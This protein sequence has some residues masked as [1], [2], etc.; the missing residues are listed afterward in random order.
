MALIIVV[1]AY[2]ALEFISSYKKSG[3][4]IIDII[5][6]DN[7]IDKEDESIVNKE[8]TAENNTDNNKEEIH[9]EQIER[10]KGVTEETKEIEKKEEKIY[11]YVTGEINTPG[12]VILNKG[13]R[14]SDAI[15]AAGGLTNKANISKINLVYIL[16]D[17]MKVNIP[18]NDDL[19]K[20]NNYEYISSG[21]GEGANDSYNVDSNSDIINRSDEKQANAEKNIV[22]INTATQTELETLPGIGPSL[23]LKIINYR[24]ENGK[25]SNIDEI[26]NVNGIGDSKFNNIKNYITV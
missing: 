3:N 1:I 12:V 24:K 10:E 16:Q 7:R 21:S 22:N 4:E 2:F 9:K 5:E 14:I 18:N 25:F 19:K 15:D 11:V 8:N 13:S 20:G 17:G 6:S 23:A 26:R